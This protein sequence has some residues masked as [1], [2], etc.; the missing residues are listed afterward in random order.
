MGKEVCRVMLSKTSKRNIALLAAAFLLCGFLH[1]LLHRADF[2]F[3]FSQLFMSALTLL[4]AMTVKKRVTD[5]RLRRLLLMVAGQLVLLYTL[6]ITKYMLLCG[7]IDAERYLWYAYYI[8]FMGIAL[9]CF[10]LALYIHRPK[11]KPLPAVSCLPAVIGALLTLGVMTNDLHFLAFRFPSGI[12]SDEAGKTNG[13]L[14]FLFAF[15]FLA[16]FLLSFWIILR[17]CHRMVRRELRFLPILPLIAL[18]AY[19]ILYLFHKVPRI[20]GINL[21]NAG[22][23]FGLCMIAFLE[24]C[25]TVGMIPANKNYEKLFFATR[26]P[27]VILDNEGM[28]VYRTAGTEYPFPASDDAKIM[29]HPIPGGCV[30]WMVDLKQVRSLNQQLEDATAQLEAR[31][32]YLAEENRIKQ[33]KA[34]VE[35][36][37]QL[38]DRIVGLLK[39]QLDQIERLLDAPEGDPDRQLAK[40][41]VINAYIKRRSNLELLSAERLDAD[42][43]T[44]AVAESLEYMRLCGVN[45]AVS[46]FGAGTYPSEMVI[47]AYEHI[48]AIAE[49]SLDTLSDMIVTVR[50]EGKELIV[51]MMLKADDFVYAANGLWH[52]GSGFSR[53]VVITKDRQDMMI[54]LT[55]T[56]GGEQS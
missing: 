1:V 25:I 32:A 53:K 41:A 50:A 12:M 24:V 42:E 44:A 28:V 22:E 52:D 4:W 7:Y 6:Q 9:T 56:E 39:P 31:N 10:Y 33:E 17:K 37:N 16:L 38:Y 20:N 54:L 55:F 46:S 19:S 27:T 40:A 2:A 30:E 43:L 47:A 11:E 45:T 35:T 8:P 48:E 23:F 26:L 34:E 21:W 5:A 29:R 36:R 15:G 3:T 14:F 49:E 51:R 18:T 13:P